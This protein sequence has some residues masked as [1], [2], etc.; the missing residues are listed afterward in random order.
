MDTRTFL[1]TVLPERGILFAQRIHPRQGKQPATILYPVGDVDD[2]SDKLLELDATYPTDN[3]YYA[4]ASYVE[5]KFKTTNTKDGKE[6]TYVVGRTQDNALAVKSLWFD[7]DVG[8]KDSYETQREAVGGVATYCKAVNLPLPLILSSGYGVHCYWVFTESVDATEWEEIAKYQRAAWRH[9]KIKVDAACDQDC[10]RVLRAPGCHNKRSGQPQKKVRVLREAVNALPP[11]EIKRRLRAYVEANALVAQ[12]QPNIPPWALGAGGNLDAALPAYPDSFAAIAVEHCMQIQQFRDTG[13][14]SEPLW[15]AH[16]GLLKHFKDGGSLAH[17]WGAKYEGYDEGETETKLD[18]WKVGPTTC[19]RFKEINAAGCEG[20]TK[21]CK[22]PLQLGYTEEVVHP[23]ITE[24]Q[25]PPP[26][27][28]SGLED[29]LDERG[30][31][32]CWPTRYGFDKATHCITTQ[33]QDEDGVWATVKLAAPLFYPVEQIRQED[34]TYALRMHVWV[35]GVQ[36]E[37]VVPTKFISD[38]RGLSSQLSQYRIRIFNPKGVCEYMADFMINMLHHMDEI[39]TY[40]QMGWHHGF[41]AFLLGN[42]LI[43]KDEERTVVLG[44]GFPTEFRNCYGKKGDPETWASAVDTLYNRE[45]GEPYQFAI[46][47]A[48]SSV[49]NP[50]LGFS[51]WSGI[52]YAMTSNNS[53]Y[54]KSTVNRIAMSIWMRQTRDTVVADSTPKALLGIA[55]ALNNVPFLMD[56]VTSYLKDPVDQTDT[57]YAMSNGAPRKGMTK[58]G[59]LRE[60]PPGWSGNYVM[61]GNRNIMHQLTEN[62]LNPEAAQMRVFEIDLET[63]PRIATMDSGSAEY[64]K[65]NTEHAMLARTIVEE[66][67]GT[68]GVDYVR[69]IMRNLDDVQERLRKVSMGMA[70]YMDGGDATKE[71]FY[72]HLITTVLVGGFYAKKMG[73]IKFD[74]LALRDWCVEHVRRLRNNA[75]EFQN[76][77]ADLFANMMS[78]M[79]GHILITKNFQSLD[80]RAKVSEFHMGATLRNPVYGRYVIGDE[81]ERPQLYITVK[82]VQQWCSENDLQYG[83]VRRD[84]LKEGL[85][86]LGNKGTNESTSASRVRLS[87]GMQGIQTLGSPWCLELDT[88]A[89]AHIFEQSIPPAEVIDLKPEAINL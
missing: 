15:Y 74:L 12:V 52:P 38:Q 83:A 73:L 89:V 56:E 29:K 28:A 65:Y 57:L 6:F 32:T 63:Y 50:M 7:L 67:Y 53:G 30:L 24:P 41:G 35:R 49:L 1:K 27:A 69:Y 48:F 51:E 71:R 88:D 8:K 39:R 11:S 23:D 87:R 76:T 36:Q 64:N 82:A 62:K 42:T 79:V 47:A 44:E 85:I 25:T 77:P 22:T 13:G 68:I 16:I 66:C 84:F 72:Y 45:H 40:R 61:T 59:R 18:Q 5:V 60:N 78:D 9:L 81:R 14:T 19:S 70:K 3:V 2:L 43:T 80:N 34:G 33:V 54:G 4:M 20:C 17:E 86:R 46:C 26:V 37:F 10:A 55:S 58:A 21:T 31:P 75:R